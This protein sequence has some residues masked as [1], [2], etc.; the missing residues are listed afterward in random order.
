MNTSVFL[1][2]RKDSRYWFVVVRKDG[3]ESTFST[4]T[5]RRR[6][7]EAI[8][9]KVATELREG[10][11]FDKPSGANI[12]LKALLEKYLAEYVAETNR[13]KT[14]GF[15]ANLARSLITR[16]GGL[17]LT[18]V[19]P[20]I[21]SKYADARRKDKRRTGDAPISATTVRHELNMLDHAFNLA[22]KRWGYLRES[23]FARYEKPS[24][25]P[26]RDR[27]L[28]D[29]ELNRLFMELPD[30]V[31]PIVTLG[32]HTGLRENNL[33]NLRWDQV[34]MDKRI[35]TIG[36]D[37]HKNGHRH[38]VAMNDTVCSMLR[39][40]LAKRSNA[41]VVS[42]RSAEYVFMSRLGKPYN[43]SGFYSIFKRACKRAGI[44][45]A[46]P[47]DLRHRFCS[48]LAARGATV[49]DIQQAAG[50]RDIRMTMKYTHASLDR[51]RKVVGLL[52]KRG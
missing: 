48:E 11:W 42:M 20:E 7:A 17:K 22:I 9:N 18:E 4:K 31:A 46:R 24:A 50:H 44:E 45:N 52:D 47:H 13:P 16:L 29:D 23:P 28:S 14:L 34:D 3:K 38:D 1:K 30:E 41:S 10:R 43:A 25:N 12:T 40:I 5:E 33:I 39:D 26:G 2:R 36:A 49:T 15:K 8:R 6:E 35:I 37:D 21:L 32:V 19:N 27:Y 51:Q